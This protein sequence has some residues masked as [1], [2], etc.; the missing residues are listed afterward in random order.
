[1]FLR[2]KL[3]EPPIPEDIFVPPTNALP[4]PPPVDEYGG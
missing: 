4:D 2:T 3:T 1:M